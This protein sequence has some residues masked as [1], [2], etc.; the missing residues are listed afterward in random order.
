MI[1]KPILNAYILECLRDLDTGNYRRSW[2]VQ[3][4]DSFRCSLCKRTRPNSDRSYE[5]VGFCRYCMG[6]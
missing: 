2:D 3:A 4:N 5:R 1:T 6:E